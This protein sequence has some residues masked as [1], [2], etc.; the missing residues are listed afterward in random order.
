VKTAVKTKHRS[1]TP[2]ATMVST[3]KSGERKGQNGAQSEY[4]EW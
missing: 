2:I 3:K 4:Q 1:V